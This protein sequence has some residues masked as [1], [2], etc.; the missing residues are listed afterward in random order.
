MF[1]VRIGLAEQ[2]VLQ[3]LAQACLQTPLLQAYPP[4]IHTA[5]KSADN[6]AFKVCGFSR[7]FYAASDDYSDLDIAD[8]DQ[9]Y[10]L[11]KYFERKIF[12][13][14]KRK[15]N[16]KCRIENFHY[17]YLVAIAKPEILTNLLEYKSFSP[18][19]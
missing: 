5:F 8:L 13:C 15:N 11:K 16:S 18:F 10:D 4:P 2:S 3:A 14:L 9:Y 7:H 12:I 6:D 19:V 1:F 17:I